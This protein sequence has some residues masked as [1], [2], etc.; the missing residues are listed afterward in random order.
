MKAKEEDLVRT[1]I[2]QEYLDKIHRLRLKF[3]YDHP[4]VCCEECLEPNKKTVSAFLVE[5]GDIIK[6]RE[7]SD[8]L[9]VIYKHTHFELRS[10]AFMLIDGVPPG[11]G[12][13]AYTLSFESLKTKKKFTHSYTAD[14]IF[15]K[16]NQ[17]KRHSVDLEKLKETN[18][19]RTRDLLR[20]LGAYV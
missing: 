7:K 10:P 3:G 4:K 15:L 14:Y 19:N 6:F 11:P 12:I 5:V 16:G 2:P 9:R 17:T 1:V 18:N 20:S 8:R 13:F